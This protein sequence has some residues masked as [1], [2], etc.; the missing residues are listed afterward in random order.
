MDP[1]AAADHQRHAGRSRKAERA[2]S[3]SAH[4]V[5]CLQHRRGALRLGQA[6]RRAR[7]RSATAAGW[8]AWAWRRRSATTCTMKS[9]ARVAARQEGRRHR[10]DRHDRHRHRQLHDHRADRG[11]DDGR[12]DR[13]RSSC[14]SAISSFPVSSGSGGQWGGNSSTAGVYAAC[15]KLREAVAQKLGFNSADVVF[16]DG[17]VRV[18]QPQRLAGRS[19]RRR[20][21]R[22]PRTRSSSATSTKTYAAVDLRRAFRRGRRRRGT[23]ARSASAGC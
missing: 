15:M 22:R 18:G 5:E 11:R 2:S 10:R 17:K 20:R 12:A 19:R 13:T 4:L 8:S 14:C 9:G 21:A 16:E 23:P 6:Q 7:A 3:R 1:V